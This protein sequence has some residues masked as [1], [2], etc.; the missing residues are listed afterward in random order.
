MN[1]GTHPA[2]PTAR[3]GDGEGEETHTDTK[4]SRAVPKPCK[5]MP[6]TP[7]AVQRTCT[8]TVPDHGA[9]GFGPSSPI[10]SCMSGT[11]ATRAVVVAWSVGAHRIA[12]REQPPLPHTFIMG[13]TSTTVWGT[14]K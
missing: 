14:E 9:P 1:L 11:K 12:E 7:L 6:T 4:L 13:S 8:R 10:P 2:M 3:R 5:G